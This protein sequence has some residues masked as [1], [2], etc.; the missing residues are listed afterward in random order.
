MRDAKLRSFDLRSF[1]IDDD[2]GRYLDRFVD[3]P[4]PALCCDPFCFVGAENQLHPWSTTQDPTR[5]RALA[6]FMRST[7]TASSLSMKC[8][9]G[10]GSVVKR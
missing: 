5:S 4:R 2:F 7:L 3:Y 10:T 9:L 1:R 8:Q 6:P